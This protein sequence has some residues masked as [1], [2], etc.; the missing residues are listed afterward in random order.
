MLRAQ[1]SDVERPAPL[2]ELSYAEVRFANG[3][4][5]L[6]F[7]QNQELLLNLSEDSL[8]RPF[9]VREGLPAPGPSL[10]GWYAA[11]A[12]APGCTFGQWL[13][14]LARMYAA[15]SNPATRARLEQLIDGYAATVDPTGKFYVHNRFPAYVYDKLVCGLTDAHTLA[16]CAQALSALERTTQAAL[17]HLPDRAYARQ[18]TPVLHGEDF[19]RHCWDES[20]TLP[21]NL[22]LAWQRTKQQRY[23]DLAVRYLM[24]GDFF[25]PLSRNENVLPGLHAY[26]HVNA[27]SSGAAA[28]LALRSEKHLPSGGKRPA[29][30]GRPELRYG[31]M[32][33][34]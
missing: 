29:D 31:R 27:L 10:G 15:D 34:G 26:S 24:D 28:Y 13:S 17:P 32:G 3:P 9:R 14:A 20:Y 22:F 6:Q 12:F 5:R 4:A 11:D 23:L 16:G 30:G 7:E 18:E 1:R 33:A 8:L 19:T 21:E 25:D 2:S